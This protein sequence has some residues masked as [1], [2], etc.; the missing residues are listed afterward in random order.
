M[1]REFFYIVVYTTT[2]Y[3]L[4]KCLMDS[5]SNFIYNYLKILMVD[6]SAIYTYIDLNQYILKLV[7]KQNKNTFAK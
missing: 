3:A 7:N 4:K 6:N 1:T 2:Y 5:C